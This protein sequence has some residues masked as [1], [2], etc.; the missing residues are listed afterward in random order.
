MDS[1]DRRVNKLRSALM[2]LQPARLTVTLKDGTTTIEDAETVW[3]FFTDANLRK[4]VMDVE[5][6][7]YSYCELAALIVALCR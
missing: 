3:R 6:D 1:V 2:P 7:Q 4:Q 5:A